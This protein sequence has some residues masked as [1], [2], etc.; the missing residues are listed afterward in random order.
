MTIV[1]L[2]ILICMTLFYITTLN[3]FKNKKTN[4]VLLRKV[5]VKKSFIKKIIFFFQNRIGG[6]MVSVLA[7]SAVD[8]GF[9]PQSGQTKDLMILVFV[10][11]P[12]STQH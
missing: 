3:I 11:S 9:E 8:R 7:S 1:D 12:L 10:A 5:L 4:R 2:D 6:V